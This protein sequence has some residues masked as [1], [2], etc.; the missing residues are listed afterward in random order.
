[1]SF[2]ILAMAPIFTPA[3]WQFDVLEFVEELS[4]GAEF[5]H[6]VDIVQ[7]DK[8]SVVLNYV[9]VVQR[10]QHLEFVL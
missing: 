3:V 1:M 5:R 7:V 6:D 9:G 10:L 2:K 8:S 4:A